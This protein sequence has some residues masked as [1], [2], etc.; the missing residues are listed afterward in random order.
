MPLKAG[1]VCSCGKVVPSNTICP[2][3]KSRKAESDKRRPSASQRG[4]D[5]KWQKA[6]SGFLKHHP[7]CAM[8][9]EPATVC[10]HII[11]HRGNM[12]LFWDRKNWQP[13]CA[14][15][16]NRTKQALER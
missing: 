3:Q 2:C 11:A 16:H 6:R 9:R 4:Y 13:L 14:T 10:D 7:I 15:H 5:S 8:C 12:T 1:H